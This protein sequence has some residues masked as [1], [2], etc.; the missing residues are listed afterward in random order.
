M[1]ES[2]AAWVDF[3]LPSLDGSL[4][5]EKGGPSHTITPSELSGAEMC[6]DVRL[7]KDPSLP[8]HHDF[9]SSEEP[10]R[11]LSPEDNDRGVGSSEYCARGN[12]G[13]GG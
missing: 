9:L 10:E 11:C 3:N 2:G 1:Q 4:M 13:R 5:P 12:G 7:A 8:V 6:R